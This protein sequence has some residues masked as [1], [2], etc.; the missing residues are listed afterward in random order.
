MKNLF[1]LLTF[2]LL[3][4]CGGPDPA[5]KTQE[6][7]ENSA[8]IEES[9]KGIF[10]E[11]NGVRVYEAI[12][13]ET[14]PDAKISLTGPMAP[15]TGLNSFEF[16]VSN[17]DLGGQTADAATRNCANS[18]KGQ[19]IHFIM[20]NGSYKAKYE[21]T[22]EEE[23]P[24]GTNVL[25]A[26]LSRSYHESIKT[27]DAHVLVKYGAGGQSL[28]EPLLFYS[29]PKGTYAGADGKKLLLDF[30]LRNVDLADNGYKVRATI[31]GN[32]FIL[33]KWCP[34]FV[35]GLSA[36]EHTF[37]LE[38]LDL[39]GD[40]VKNAQSEGGNSVVGPYSDTGER[41]INITEG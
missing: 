27:N 33:P 20:N 34:Y 3:L 28:S 10:M 25:L 13:E 41:I 38:L 29:R 30:Y 26:F 8:P 22:F 6:E 5:E 18:A 19:H 16:E 11:N 23:V 7:A 32:E 4:S 15:N 17:Y 24:E 31:D 37:R 40:P 14:F 12:V 2:C 36:G 39:N 9:V 35:E 21:S 1:P